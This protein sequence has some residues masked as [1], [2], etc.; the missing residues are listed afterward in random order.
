[1]KRNIIA[2]QSVKTKAA[3]T[4]SFIFFFSVFA[5]LTQTYGTIDL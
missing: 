2:K 5:E 4:Q 1:M 3:E